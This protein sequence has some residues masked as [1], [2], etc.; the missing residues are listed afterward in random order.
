MSIHSN[1]KQYPNL[2]ENTFTDAKSAKYLV[3][4]LKQEKF[5]PYARKTTKLL[6][7]S[8]QYFGEIIKITNPSV[9]DWVL[10][11]W[12]QHCLKWCKDK[13]FP[14][15]LETNINYIIITRYRQLKIVND[16]RRK[17]QK[18]I[19]LSMTKENKKE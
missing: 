14:K 6:G 10:T 19:Q 3:G 11:Q 9:C 12:K 5:K 1:K 15:E 16:D 7:S 13:Q 8:L 2:D 17:L 4:L 18:A